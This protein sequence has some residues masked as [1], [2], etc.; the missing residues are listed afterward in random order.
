M[1]NFSIR[2]D[3]HLNLKDLTNPEPSTA[4]PDI[5]KVQPPA[6]PVLQL[7]LHLAHMLYHLPCLFLALRPRKL[8]FVKPVAVCDVVV[9]F[10]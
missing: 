3:Q 1:N 7:P 8:F 4:P 10:L 6:L 5:H 2:E 9:E